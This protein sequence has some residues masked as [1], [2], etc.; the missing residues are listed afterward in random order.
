MS[1]V[2]SLN[3]FE[4]EN[5]SIDRQSNLGE[6]DRVSYCS[7]TSVVSVEKSKST[8][9]NVRAKESSPDKNQEKESKNSILQTIC[10]GLIAVIALYGFLAYIISKETSKRSGKV[11]F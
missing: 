4:L 11:I 8:K 5:I 7:Q 9:S 6:E 3:E 1:T 10:I 2:S